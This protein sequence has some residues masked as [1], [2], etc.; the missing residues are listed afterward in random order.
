[1]FIFSQGH[2]WI[3]HSSTSGGLKILSTLCYAGNG[4]GKNNPA[5]QNV[6]SVGPLPQ[7]LYSIGLPYTDPE[8]GPNTMR[9]TPAPL[10]QMFNRGEFLIHADYADPAKAGTASEGCCV[11]P[12]DPRAVIAG[13][14]VA[15]DNTLVV[16]P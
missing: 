10:N 13:S 7:G 2:G 15:G 16:V 4:A 14:V 8:R 11:V 9:L 5:M 6:P 3:A 12:H 1:M